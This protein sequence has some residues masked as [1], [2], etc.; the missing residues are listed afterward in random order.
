MN[1]NNPNNNNHSNMAED[2]LH[3]AMAQLPDDLTAA[4]REA[5]RFAP[6]LIEKE[7][8]PEWFLR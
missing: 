7:S 4:Y 1:N 2:R 6:E 3:V 8:K 5:C